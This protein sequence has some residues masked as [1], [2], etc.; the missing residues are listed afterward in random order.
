MYSGDVVAAF[1]EAAT[2]D[3]VTELFVTQSTAPFVIV[4]GV[5]ARTLP[6]ASA[7]VASSAPA[8]V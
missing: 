7:V 4:I 2:S 3:A 1:I 5:P 6:V 8:L